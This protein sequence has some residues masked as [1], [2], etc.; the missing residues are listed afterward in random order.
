M[1]VII[2][3]S[4]QNGSKPYRENGSEDEVED[5]GGNSFP[6]ACFLNANRHTGFLVLKVE[7]AHAFLCFAALIYL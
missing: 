4:R 3:G 7:R 1:A 2:N 6:K 5:V